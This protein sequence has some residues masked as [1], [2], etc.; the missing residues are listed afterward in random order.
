MTNSFEDASILAG[1]LYLKT[2]L[3][4]PLEI[5][6]RRNPLGRV[7]GEVSGDLETALRY[8]ADNKPV[9]IADYIT[10]LRLVRNQIFSLKGGAR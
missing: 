3:N 6:F 2:Y 1:L 4:F 8:I 7:N 10:C 5:N 9:N